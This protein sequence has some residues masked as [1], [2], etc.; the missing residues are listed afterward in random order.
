MIICSLTSAINKNEM[1]PGSRIF[2]SFIDL[3]GLHVY[4]FYSM[5]VFCATYIS[6]KKYHAKNESASLESPTISVHVNL[7]YR[8]LWSMR[9]IILYLGKCLVVL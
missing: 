2:F 3:V 1:S 7:V 6:L 4:T 8:Y 9:F 5:S